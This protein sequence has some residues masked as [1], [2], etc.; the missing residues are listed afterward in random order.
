MLQY[1]GA[2]DISHPGHALLVARFISDVK[3]MPLDEVAEQLARNMMKLYAI[4]V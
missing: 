2:S 4:N 1:K 3:Q